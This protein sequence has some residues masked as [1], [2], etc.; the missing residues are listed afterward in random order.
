MTE[1][2]NWLGFTESVYQAATLVSRFLLLLLILFFLRRRTPAPVPAVVNLPQAETPP[3]FAGRR[4]VVARFA[5]GSGI[6]WLVV[7]Y[8]GPTFGVEWK[9]GDVQKRSAA[10]FANAKLA[11]NVAFERIEAEPVGV[12]KLNLLEAVRFAANEAGKNPEHV[13]VLIDHDTHR[14]MADQR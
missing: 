3:A 2:L 8:W 5:K 1:F 9:E 13:F 7:P 6:R 10:D 14:T 11:D 4:Y 12:S